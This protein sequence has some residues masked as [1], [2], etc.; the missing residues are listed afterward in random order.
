MIVLFVCKNSGCMLSTLGRDYLEDL[1]PICSKCQAF[2]FQKTPYK[3]LYSRWNY[4]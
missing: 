2:A 1:G 3:P 4:G